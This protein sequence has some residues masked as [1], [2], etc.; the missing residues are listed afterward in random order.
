MARPMSIESIGLA[1]AKAQLSD[2]AAR[3]PVSLDR[4]RE[5]TDGMPTQ[6]QSAG[7]FMRQQ[8]NAERY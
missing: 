3:R 4:L 5:V 1:E 8:R 6:P 7:Q 2:L